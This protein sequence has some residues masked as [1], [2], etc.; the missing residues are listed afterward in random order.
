MANLP[1][2]C[3]KSKRFSCFP[4]KGKGK[5]KE[6]EE[7]NWEG[8]KKEKERNGDRLTALRGSPLSWQTLFFCR[9]GHASMTSYWTSNTHSKLN[10]G[11]F[12]FKEL[13]FN[14]KTN[15]WSKMNVYERNARKLR[16]HVILRELQCSAVNFSSFQLNGNCMADSFVK[17][18]DGNTNARH[19]EEKVVLPENVGFYVFSVSRFLPFNFPDRS[20]FWVFVFFLFSWMFFS[21]ILQYSFE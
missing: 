3:R 18:F 17:H 21:I 4:E 20:D 8:I 9:S 10:I 15:N 6:K 1:V 13:S 12:N 7:N 19:L 2:T 16:I 11:Y 14:F 5:R